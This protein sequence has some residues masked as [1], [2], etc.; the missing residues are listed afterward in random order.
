VLLVHVLLRLFYFCKSLLKIL[1][2]LQNGLWRLQRERLVLLLY[3]A[4]EVLVGILLLVSGDFGH[5]VLV[6]APKLASQLPLLLLIG[7][8][9]LGTLLKRLF[10]LP[11]VS[12]RLVKPM[13]R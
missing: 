12:Y 2:V 11:E 5:R 4:V 8:L 13:D 1:G 3:H 7:G 9:L 10:N 6:V